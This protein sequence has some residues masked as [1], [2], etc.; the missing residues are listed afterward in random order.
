MEELKKY[1][2]GKVALG[3]GNLQQAFSIVHRTSKS[4]ELKSTFGGNPS[5]I[6]T[7]ARTDEM[8]FKVLIREEGVERDYDRAYDNDETVQ[9]RMK[10]PGKTITVTGEIQEMETT[11][12]Q[13]QAVEKSVKVIGVGST[14]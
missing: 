7:G 1:L 10:V 3:A 9:I 2:E 4:K 6:T 8:T 13:G 5:G 14:S 12:E 11:A